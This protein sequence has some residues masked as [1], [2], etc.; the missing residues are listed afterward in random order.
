MGASHGTAASHDTAATQERWR[1]LSAAASA[2]SAANTTHEKAQAKH[3]V[4]PPDSTPQYDAKPM[5]RENTAPFADQEQLEFLDSLIEKARVLQ[6][7]NLPSR[8]AT[9]RQL[10]DCLVAW[11]ETKAIGPEEAR[12][13]D[14]MLT[15]ARMSW[16]A[17]MIVN[18]LF[19]T[20]TATF[21]FDTLTIDDEGWPLD[22]ST[23]LACAT[24]SYVLI[25]LG[26]SALGFGF[27][28]AALLHTYSMTLTRYD[29]LAWFFATFRIEV[30]QLTGLLGA[31]CFFAG[32]SVHAFYKFGSSPRAIAGA[33]IWTC[34][35]LLAVTVYLKVRKA[36]I[37]RF[38]QRDAAVAKMKSRVDAGLS[39]SASGR[40]PAAADELS[41]Q[42]SRAFQRVSGL[43]Q[44]VAGQNTR[45]HL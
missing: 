21:S 30:V 25:S 39:R 3:E 6:A 38:R 4:M 36:F 24:A 45:L 12:Q 2:A 7:S 13:L 20:L 37:A 16:H 10:E 8:Y 42:P 33:V 34:T 5:R 43:K 26:A 1:S 40:L 19:F 22:A 32:C 29:D 44:P 31:F 15:N 41:R 35:L 23:A 28:Y 18:S 14:A 27:C 9:G 11:R 17:F